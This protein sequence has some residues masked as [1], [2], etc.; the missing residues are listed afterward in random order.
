MLNSPST[1]DGLLIIGH[2]TRERAGQADFFQLVELV[3]QRSEKPVEGCFLEFA[4]PT[5]EE[6]FDRLIARGVR[7]VTAVPLLLFAAGHA[8]R[9]IPAALSQAAAGHPGVETRQTGPLECDS[10]I[11]VLSARRFK[12][13]I[14]EE[15]AIDPA[16]ILL[17]FVGR[18][19]A[20]PTATAE[21]RRFAELRAAHTP[22][23]RVNVCFLAIQRP[24]LAEG[25]AEAA[26]S[27]FTRIVVQPHLLFRGELF[28]EI[29]AAVAAQPRR[30]GQ[31][32]FVA[33]ML[34]S[35][36]ELATAVLEL[37]SGVRP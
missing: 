12:E 29:R 22:V 28:D 30:A 23:G 11:L 2:G 37:A 17:L 25:L 27:K 8:K 31:E 3:R 19:S 26:A 9:D 10:Q 33:S 4:A 21:M 6:G 35:E 1:A 7:R 24:T 36:L 15:P 14:A 34:G 20:D 5:I 32:W 16:E 13:A 18:G